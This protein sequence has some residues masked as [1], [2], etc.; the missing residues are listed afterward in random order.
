MRNSSII[1][2]SLILILLVAIQSCKNRQAI[3]EKKFV[4]IYT[5]MIFMKD[6]SS[7]SQLEIKEELLKRF[8]VHENDYDNTIKYYN[9]D[10]ERWQPFFD[11]IIT[12]IEKI[13][14]K[15]KKIDVKSLP[16]QSVSLDKKDL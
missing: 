2:A 3:E 5:D 16:E 11:S 6:T 8:N 10:P 9:D 15:P 14:P 1:F 4:K 7:L 13:K 12:Y